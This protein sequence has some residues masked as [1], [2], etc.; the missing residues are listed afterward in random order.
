MRKN[1]LAFL[2]TFLMVIAIPVGVMAFS[3]ND[4]EW[5]SE[6]ACIHPRCDHGGFDHICCHSILSLA[7]EG[8]DFRIDYFYQ[9]DGLWHRV[10][11]PSSV[12][13][14]DGEVSAYV[15]RFLCCTFP[16][17]TTAV[18]IE[19]HRFNATGAPPWPC[20]GVTRTQV[21]F[22]NACGTGHSPVHQV[23]LPGCGNSYRP[24]PSP[25]PGPVK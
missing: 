25:S 13:L 2:L 19:T 24:E 6:L 14:L 20:I 1:V 21:V 17:I 10:V 3:H 8:I 16:L 11:V 12:I 22:C 23:E 7:E 9:G 5:G 4:G 18:L 15:R